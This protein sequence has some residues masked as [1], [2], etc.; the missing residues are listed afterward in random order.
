M[1]YTKTDVE[2]AFRQIARARG[3][4]INPDDVYS[5]MVPAV[6][7]AREGTR[8]TYAIGRYALDHAACYGGYRIVRCANENGGEH[9]VTRLRLPARQFCEAARFMA[10]ALEG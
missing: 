2:N 8:S 1:R 5:L 3:W 10:D 7:S 9:E 6:S 4:D